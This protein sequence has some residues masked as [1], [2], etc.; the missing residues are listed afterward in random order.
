MDLDEKWRAYAEEVWKRTSWGKKLLRRK[1]TA[2]VGGGDDSEVRVAEFRDAE[3]RVD[4][5]L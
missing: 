1:G 4:I 5:R 2:D 3:G